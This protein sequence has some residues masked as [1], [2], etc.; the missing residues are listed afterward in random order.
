MKECDVA[1]YIRKPENEIVDKQ[2]VTS[3]RP[4]VSHLSVNQTNESARQHGTAQNCRETTDYFPLR[5]Q[6]TYSVDDD[7]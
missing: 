7:C 5:I 1:V 2:A 4:D 3:G 6:C